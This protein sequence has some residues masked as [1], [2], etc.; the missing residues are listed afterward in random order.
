MPIRV[1]LVIPVNP[2]CDGSL[3]LNFP[4]ASDTHAIKNINANVG[5]AS[6]FDFYQ[7]YGDTKYACSA[8]GWS[9]YSLP[10]RVSG[11]D[12]DGDDVFEPEC[13]K[14]RSNKAG[15]VEVNSAALS[16]YSKSSLMFRVPLVRIPS[17]ISLGGISLGNKFNL[18]F[19]AGYEFGPE[20]EWRIQWPFHWPKLSNPAT[21]CV[22]MDA[23]N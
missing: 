11:K 21:I 22:V 3:V 1:N 13:P 16:L 9:G 15:P 8:C 17:D 6:M 18:G 2:P 12:E 7:I 5:A 14:C 4:R 20:S 10:H 23:V 19:L